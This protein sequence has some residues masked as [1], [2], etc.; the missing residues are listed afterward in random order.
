MKTDATQ[1]GESRSLAV[2]RFKALECALRAKSEFNEFALAMREYFEISHAEPVP[3]SE[4]KRPYNEV[5]Y[6]P[7]YTVRKQ[8]STTS[9][10]RA[11]FDAST[12]SSSE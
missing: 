2:G 9:K 6:L 12:K 3:A 11:I 8:F 5:H 10:V 1:L 7:M 4:L